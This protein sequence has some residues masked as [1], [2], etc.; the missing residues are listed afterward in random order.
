MCGPKFCSMEIT[1]Q[2]RDYAAAQG[3]A[4]EAEARERGMAEK[5]R[6]FQESGGEIYVEAP[7]T[8]APVTT[9]DKRR[10]P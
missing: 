7:L 2:I 3:L 10:E 9:A 8:T 6:D 1:Q 5:S 4:S